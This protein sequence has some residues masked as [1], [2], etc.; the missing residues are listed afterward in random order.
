M[1]HSE[2]SCGDQDRYRAKDRKAKRKQLEVNESEAKRKQLKDLESEAK[3]RQLEE[4]KSIGVQMEYDF[5]QFERLPS[6]DVFSVVFEF[7]KGDLPSKSSVT[8][9][10]QLLMTLMKLR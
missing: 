5:I 4:P 6:W 2:A 7:V 8:P 10:H 3:R 1:W 9:F